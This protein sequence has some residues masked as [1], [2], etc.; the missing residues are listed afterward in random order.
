MKNTAA[1]IKAI[2]TQVG[3]SVALDKLEAKYRTEE[4]KIML[5]DPIF[6]AAK[7]AAMGVAYI[8]DKLATEITAIDQAKEALKVA[9]AELLKAE[10][11]FK[12]ER[13]HMIF[14]L[15]AT[16]LKDL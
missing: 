11:L 7:P 9:N 10:T 1:Y 3:A 4:I 5:H 6:G 15:S 2:E 8:E 12:E 14:P 16:Q 13:N